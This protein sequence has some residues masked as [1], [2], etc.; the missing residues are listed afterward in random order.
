MSADSNPSC[1]VLHRFAQDLKLNGKSPRTQQAYT[2]ALRKFAEYLGHAPDTAT[3]D[4][5]RNYLLHIAQEN[6]WSASTINVAQQA[7][8]L[9]YRI[10]CPRDWPVLRLARVQVER[11]LPVVLSIG[12]VQTI[13]KLI[14]KH[15]MRC[16]FNV[17]YALGLRL[18]EALNLQ[19]TDI[20][21][22]RMLVHIH[23]GN[24]NGAHP[25]IGFLCGEQAGAGSAERFENDLACF[26]V[27][28]KDVLRQRHRKN[29]RV[30]DVLPD[31][32]LVPHDADHAV[33]DAVVLGGCAGMR[34]AA[35]LAIFATHRRR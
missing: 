35:D 3:E 7:I 23:R 6:D 8:K 21:A 22:Q 17:T 25:A 26:G 10:T 27:S 1:P 24:F 32:A 16:Y 15:S 20:D 4:Q 31:L 33:G 30:V 11:K 9:F 2:R 34:P 18:Q 13:L 19:V 29:C 14:E 28:I 5:L 12:E